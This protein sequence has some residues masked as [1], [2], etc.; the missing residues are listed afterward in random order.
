LGVDA[1]AGRTFL[2]ADDQGTGDQDVAVISYKYW[3]RRFAGSGSAVGQTVV[4]NQKPFTIVGVTPPEFYGTIVGASPDIFLPSSAGERILPGRFRFRDSW[5]PFV[6]GRLKPGV[7]EAQAAGRATLLIQQADL[8]S[9]GSDPTTKEHQAVQKQTFR[10]ES[11]RQGFNMLREEFSA[12]LRLLMALVGLVLLIACANVANL[13]MV[14]IVGRRKEI[15][16]RLALGPA[17][18]GLFNRCW[19]KAF[20]WQRWAE[21]SGCCWHPGR[22]V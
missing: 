13:L 10:L 20:C 14:R 16:V 17:V 12:P 9:A 3:R 11:A 8:A 5:L 15:A 22:T 4:L 1:V 2:V 19:R 6:M 18:C 21:R 7:S